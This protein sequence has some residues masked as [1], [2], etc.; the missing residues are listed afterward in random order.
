MSL[1]RSSFSGTHGVHADFPSEHGKRGVP[2]IGSR[3]RGTITSIPSNDN[4]DNLDE[5]FSAT[6]AACLNDAH[7]MKAPGVEP[8]SVHSER[9]V[10]VCLIGYAMSFIVFGSQVRSS[11][12]QVVHYL[13]GGMTSSGYDAFPSPH[14]L[15]K[16][17]YAC[18]YASI[19]II[20]PHLSCYFR[21]YFMPACS[22]NEF[23]KQ[24]QNR[25]LV[26][27]NISIYICIASLLLV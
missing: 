25:F 19:N 3:S 8:P 16:F 9:Y 7:S 11:Q 15:S 13:S 21:S 2:S 18:M 1:G 17:C 6:A 23:V 14:F 22:I 5:V 12:T 27:S 26:I 24:T 20:I 10:M 4:L